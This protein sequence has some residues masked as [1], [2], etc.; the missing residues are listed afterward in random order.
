MADSTRRTKEEVQAM[1][2]RIM[3][4]RLTEH[5]LDEVS[6]PGKFDDLEFRM[7]KLFDYIEG[8]QSP[9]RSGIGGL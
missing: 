6:R 3:E 9:P 5:F 2:S 7:G 1:V 8:K 4:Q